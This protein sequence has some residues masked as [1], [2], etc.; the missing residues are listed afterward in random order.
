M[1]EGNGGDPFGEV[2][3]EVLE[4]DLAAISTAPDPSPSVLDLECEEGWRAFVGELTDKGRSSN[5]PGYLV[6]KG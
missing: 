2:G 4:V 3:I 6:L 5:K 1:I